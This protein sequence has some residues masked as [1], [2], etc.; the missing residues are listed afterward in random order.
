MKETDYTKY[1]RNVGRW[2]CATFALLALCVL[3]TIAIIVLA[4]VKDKMFKAMMVPTCSG[5]T[6]SINLKIPDRPG[7]FNDLTPK[8]MKGLQMYLY[9]QATLNLVEPSDAA[10]NNSYI[11]LADLYLP[12]KSDVLEHLDNN[13]KQ[14]IRQAKVVIFR[15]D[16]AVP[17]IEEYIVGPL[18]TPTT[19]T[20][21]Q[22]HRNTPI[23]FSYRPITGPEMKALID[24]ISKEADDLLSPFLKEKY[25]ATFTDCGDR[26]LAFRFFTPMSRVITGQDSRKMWIWAHHFVEFYVLNPIDFDVLVRLDNKAIEV[27]QIWHGDR[28]YASF[29]QLKSEYDRGA[30]RTAKIPFPKVDRDYF[31]TM[32]LRGTRVPEQSTRNPVQ[33]E[34]DGKRY[35]IDGRHV[36]YMGWDLDFRMSISSGPQLFDIKYRGERIAYELSLQE[37]A[38]FYS[39]GKPAQK[40]ANYIDSVGLIGASGRGL[41]PG[42]D[43]PKGATLVNAEFMMESSKDPSIAYNAFCIFEFNTG[44]PLRRHH[45]YTT[46]S[47]HYYEGVEDV[48]LTLRTIVTIANYDY[49]FD[50]TFHQNGAIEVRA[51]STGYILSEVFSDSEKMYGIQLHNNITGVVHHHMFQFKADLDIKGTSNSF[52]T[53]NIVPE[54]VAINEWSV[55]PNAKYHQTK[56]V[57]SIKSHEQDAAY[58]FNFNSPKY[59]VFYNDNSKSKYGNS[60]GYRVLINGMSKQMIREGEGNEPAVSWARYQMAVTKMKDEEREA[61]SIYAMWDADD[62]VVQFQHFINDNEAILNQVSFG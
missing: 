29:S 27:E 46:F 15:G 39:A 10:V 11:F 51:I 14:P 36:S 57:E 18:P 12:R 44:V 8:E 58:R 23:P 9:A 54:E 47:G 60:R 30:I 59:L 55:K 50:F 34:P 20:P 3:L 6:N 24:K 26:C 4:M 45:A 19:H 38:V 49:I 16:K 61:S 21:L 52:K 13:A 28:S 5:K 48:V 37:L 53:L 42:A 7:V 41:I 22:R 31:S 62:P 35:S 40:F 1:R 2:R 56:V 43:C 32:N 25:G 33:I 17:D